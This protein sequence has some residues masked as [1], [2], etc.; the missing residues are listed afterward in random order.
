MQSFVRLLLVYFLSTDKAREV[1]E[2]GTK[3]L[4][5]AKALVGLARRL[6]IKPRS[7]LNAYG[8]SPA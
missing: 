2:F 3:F 7:K 1:S 8:P 5:R 4:E 6:T